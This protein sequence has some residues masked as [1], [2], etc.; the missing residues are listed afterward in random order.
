MESPDDEGRPNN[1]GRLD[2]K[3]RP[4]DGNRLVDDSRPD[5]EG[6]QD[7]ERIPENEDSLTPETMLDQARACVGTQDY[8]CATRLFLCYLELSPADLGVRLELARV[9]SW[10]ERY[11]DAVREYDF[12]HRKAPFDRE[13][14]LERDRVL[15]W[16]GHYVDAIVSLAALRAESTRSPHAGTSRRPSADSSQSPHADSSKSPHADSSQSPHVDSS[17]SVLAPDQEETGSLTGFSSTSDDF[18]ERVTRALADGY[19]WSG[20]EQRALPLYRS[21]WEHEQDD[22]SLGLAYAR[23]LA[24]EKAYAEAL[25]VYDALLLRPPADD[26]LQPERPP[27]DEALQL[28]RPPAGDTLQPER[29]PADEAL[30][31]ERAR[32]LLWAERYAEGLGCLKALREE[33][34]KG[35]TPQNETQAARLDEID[36]LLASGYYWSG[37]LKSAA[38]EFS[39]LVLVHPQDSDLLLDFARVLLQ[40]R[41]MQ[42][43]AVQ[44]RLHLALEP[45]DLMAGVEHASA[46]L[47]AEQYSDAT[48]SCLRLKAQLEEPAITRKFSSQEREKARDDVDHILARALLWGGQPELALPLLRALIATFPDEAGLELD[49]AQCLAQLGELDDAWHA[50]ARYREKGGSPTEAALAEGQ[51]LHWQGGILKARAQYREAIRSSPASTEAAGRLASLEPLLTRPW[52]TNVRW[53]GDV[54]GFD[55]ETLVSSVELP[56]GVVWTSPQAA[57]DRFGGGDYDIYRFSPT[58]RARYWHN[59]RWEFGGSAGFRYLVDDTVSPLAPLAGANARWLP[60]PQIIVTFNADLSDA[61]DVLFTRPSLE[62]G[63]RRLDFSSSLDWIRFAS[64]EAWAQARVTR[65]FRQGG[66]FPNQ[67]LQVQGSL[68][69]H[70]LPDESSVRLRLAAVGGG[71]H[72]AHENST[73]WSPRLYLSA[74]MRATME[75]T[76]FG[77]L[78]TSAGVRI[79]MGYSTE[80]S[81]LFP[82]L[83]GKIAMAHH[84]GEKLS[85]SLEADYGQ[86]ARNGLDTSETS[87]GTSPGPRD[88][89]LGHVQLQILY[90]F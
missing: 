57:I 74:G 87:G 4:V 67:L 35:A 24:G 28:E 11:E 33:C 49:L 22:F 5:I 16:A 51:L 40:A 85:G 70:L 68:E 44:Y 78:N 77:W 48:R 13:L 1:G 8:P 72:V 76:L 81:E 6:N 73:Y 23:I 47:W 52:E 55:Q 79:G 7:T 26:T 56:L 64:W 71:L 53:R 41:R 69:R 30:Q 63:V 61:D 66:G 90:L 75:T 46:L 12:L 65:L 25:E 38:T 15:L 27:G 19:A 50:F 21:L 54:D 45:D 32:V 86:T 17:G 29:P 58:L 3:G 43:A 82:E 20:A 36:R 59:A 62:A 84:F 60:K 34:L 88:Y 89:G 2:S 9:Y 83:A 42:E 31:L 18:N 80:I 10:S 37:D 39:R 14:S